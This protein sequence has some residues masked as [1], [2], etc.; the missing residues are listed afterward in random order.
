MTRDY[1][2]VTKDV[3]RAIA[4]ARE[5]I[6]AEFDANNTRNDWIAYATAYTGRAAE[7][8]FRNEGEDAYDMLVKAAGLLVEAAVRERFIGKGDPE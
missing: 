4:Y 1:E 7:K 6:D 3:E 2:K 8:V 5:K